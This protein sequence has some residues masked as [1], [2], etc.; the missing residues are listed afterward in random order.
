VVGE[1]SHNLEFAEIF[2]VK[3]IQLVAFDTAGANK[4]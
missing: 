2:G 1:K 4:E 3:V